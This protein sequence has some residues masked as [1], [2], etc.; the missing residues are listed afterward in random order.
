MPSIQSILHRQISRWTVE[1][2]IHT[3]SAGDK[4]RP[5]IRPADAKPVLTF[6]RERGCRGRQLAQVLAD[7]L[8]YGILDRELIDYIAENT[9]AHRDVIET[10]DDRDRSDLELWVDGM[11]HGRIVDKDDYIRALSEAIKAAAIQGG[12][13]IMGRGSNYLLEDSYIFRIRVVAPIEFRVQT[14]IE[15]EGKTEAE[16]RAEI[17]RADSERAHFV[18]RY[19]RRDINDPT[20]YDLVINAKTVSVESAGKIVLSALR[21]QGWPMA[22]TG[23]DKRA[24]DRA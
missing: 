1:R 16:A 21:A 4:S 13:I 18:K 5:V 10:L 19:F 8:E 20:A 6:S 15:T 9:G 24:R 2:E 7:S 14:L 17:E 23:G 22:L 11:L 3:K 12:V